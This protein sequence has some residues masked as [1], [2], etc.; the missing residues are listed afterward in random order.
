M[1]DPLCRDGVCNHI[2]QRGFN[3]QADKQYTILILVDETVVPRLAHIPQIG[4]LL[5]LLH[6][7]YDPG[8]GSIGQ[9][10]TLHREHGVFI[11]AKARP[12]QTRPRSGTP[13][14]EPE[15]DQTLEDVQEMIIP[16]AFDVPLS[17]WSQLS[18]EPAEQ[19][20]EDDE[21]PILREGTIWQDRPTMVKKALED[22]TRTR[23]SC[24]LIQEDIICL[25]QKVGTE[26][27]ET[28]LR[29]LHSRNPSTPQ[30]ILGNMASIF[31]QSGKMTRTQAAGSY[32]FKVSDACGYGLFVP[33]LFRQKPGFQQETT[34]K[35]YIIHGTTCTGAS[36][37]LAE[38][39]L[40]PGDFSMHHDHLFQSDFPPYGHCSVGLQTEEATL[41]PLKVRH[42]TKK[43]LQT[44]QG[45]MAAFVCGTYAGR[46]ACQNYKVEHPDEAQ[47]L[48]GKF[49]IAKGPHNTVVTPRNILR[50]VL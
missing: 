31:G 16:P 30:M 37:I 26:K 17:D 11:R 6:H 1:R 48:C 19:G 7:V 38:D 44:S 34:F 12:I 4:G 50:L 10:Q 15:P 20:Q 29:I 14:P 24:E 27:Y 8:L 33:T 5:A 13:Q 21:V 41:V 9:D 2:G 40:R 49:G 28:F 46:Y 25:T 36:T 35:Y 39:L 47:V 18:P 22:P 42:L 45:A 43:I 3:H 23:A 32:T